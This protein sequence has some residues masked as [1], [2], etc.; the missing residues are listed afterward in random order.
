VSFPKHSF[1]R[2]FAYGLYTWF[3][4]HNQMDAYLGTATNKL[5]HMPIPW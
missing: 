5:G 4:R 2:S 1:T 3:T